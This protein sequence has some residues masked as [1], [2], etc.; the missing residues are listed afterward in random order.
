MKVLV[1]IYLGG[2]WVMAIC[3][4]INSVLL[5]WMYMV[6]YCVYGIQLY[7][8]VYFCILCGGFSF[9]G[10]GFCFFYFTFSLFYFNVSCEGLFYFVWF[11]V[12]FVVVLFF[13]FLELFD[14][15]E[16]GVFRCFLVFCFLL[17][18]ILTQT[19]TQ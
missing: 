9:F 17:S 13:C 2:I 5:V 4:I 1:S 12:Y 3:I 15:Y 10:F 7:T 19:I 18:C 16:V 6:V 11:F 8:F 14:I